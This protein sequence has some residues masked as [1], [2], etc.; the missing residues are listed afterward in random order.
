MGDRGARGRE[1]QI[2]KVGEY[3]RHNKDA[4]IQVFHI[5][6]N[7]ILMDTQTILDTST[8]FPHIVFRI[9]NHHRKTYY[10]DEEV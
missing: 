10:H 1:F 6:Y 7:W 8:A 3:P 9:M 2:G 4:I 5:N